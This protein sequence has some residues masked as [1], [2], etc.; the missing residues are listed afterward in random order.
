MTYLQPVG[1]DDAF[2]LGRRGMNSLWLRV[3]AWLLK[4]SPVVTWEN[5]LGEECSGRCNEAD[6]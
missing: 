5:V 3:V 2:P 1:E 4:V 6:I